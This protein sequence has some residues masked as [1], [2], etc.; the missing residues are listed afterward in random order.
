MSTEQLEKIR[1]IMEDV[2]TVMLTTVSQDGTLVSRPMATQ[3]AEFDGDAWF[4]L[5]LDSDLARDVAA[6]PAVN[7]AYSGSSSWLS[8][9][10]QAQVVVDEA[11]KAELWNPFVESWFPDGEHD[12]RVVLLK[13]TAGSAQYWD[14]PGRVAV[15]L[16]M[17]KARVTG[18]QA[19]DVAEVGTVEL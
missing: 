17:L 14:S 8:L 5:A 4:I 7:L 18:T 11:K 6:Q 10:G 1:S 19:G 15:L 3:E 13:V 2:R 16:D 12:P 9:S